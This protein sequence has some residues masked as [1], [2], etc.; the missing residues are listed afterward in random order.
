M[1]TCNYNTLKICRCNNFRWLLYTA[2]YYRSELLHSSLAEL[3]VANYTYNTPNISR[4]KTAFITHHGLFKFCVMPFGLTN[5]PAVFQRLMQKVLSDLKTDNGRD[6]AEVYIDDVLI[7]SETLGEHLQH[8][9]LVLE[10]L[11]KAGLKLKPAKC[12]FLRESVEYLGHLITP[13]G[14]KP[15]PKQVKAVVEFP[16]PESVTN[17]RQF[18]G[19]TSYYRRFI[20][21]FAK[22]AAPLHALTCKDAVF[23]WTTECQEAF[24]ALKAAITRSP[25]LAY[26]NFDVDFVLETDASVKGLGS[27]AVTVPE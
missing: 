8:I 26:P 10:R 13:Q 27:H 7:F 14:L 18:L 23:R 16:V 25:V 24:E 11:K 15:N 6:F 5:A 17:V 19:L 22:V 12:H 2:G 4:E 20:A 9:R 1:S 3:Q 21:Q